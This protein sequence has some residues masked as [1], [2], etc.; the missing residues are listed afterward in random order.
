V[1]ELQLC[2]S[3]S[4]ASS[5]ESRRVLRVCA[6][7]IPDRVWVIICAQGGRGLGFSLIVYIVYRWNSY[8]I[9]TNSIVY[10]V[11]WN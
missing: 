11:Y 10:I 6:C 2:A 3:L 7:L 4:C 9:R 5:R 8:A 1:S